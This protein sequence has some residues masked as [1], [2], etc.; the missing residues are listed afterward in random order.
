MAAI[1][2]V[3]QVPYVILIIDIAYGDDWF[4]E[5]CQAENMNIDLVESK[6]KV[7]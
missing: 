6:H 2:K 4:Q 3:E 7:T 1:K 5:N